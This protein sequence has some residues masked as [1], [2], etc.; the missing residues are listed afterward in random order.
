VNAILGW[1]GSGVNAV[2][3]AMMQAHSK[4]MNWAVAEKVKEKEATQV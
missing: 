2:R 4:M 3:H 1:Q